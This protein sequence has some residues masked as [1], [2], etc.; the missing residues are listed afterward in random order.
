MAEVSFSGLD[1]LMLSMEE[2][3]Q[4]P[5]TVKDEKIGRAHV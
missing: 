1:E 4:I 2:V 3:A 5:D